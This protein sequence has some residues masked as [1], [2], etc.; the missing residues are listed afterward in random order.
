VT[1]SALVRFKTDAKQPINGSFTQVE[2]KEGG[3]ST[4]PDMDSIS[5]TL[6]EYE[7]HFVPNLPEELGG[8]VPGESFD[9]GSGPE[10]QEIIKTT[11]VEILEPAKNEE[12][13]QQ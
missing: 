7:K 4:P 3:N 13:Q 12:Q 9:T 1:V 8:A 2:D 11:K 6:D 10:T 5:L